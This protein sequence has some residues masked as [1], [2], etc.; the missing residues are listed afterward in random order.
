MLHQFHIKYQTVKQNITITTNVIST[1]CH[2]LTTL[3]NHYV[4]YT[5]LVEHSLWADLVVLDEKISLQIFS[6][7]RMGL[8]TNK[9]VI[10]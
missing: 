1:T 8:C 10:Q 3:T 5:A 4:A 6:H 2:L 9:C 7:N